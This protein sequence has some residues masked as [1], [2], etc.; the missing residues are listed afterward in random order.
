MMTSNRK[1]NV[2][3]QSTLIPLYKSL[4]RPHLENCCLVWNPHFRKDIELI[5]GFRDEQ[6]NW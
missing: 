3:R 4:V 1:N 2:V 5:E 6:Q